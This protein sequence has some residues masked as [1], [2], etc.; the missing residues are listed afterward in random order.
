MDQVDPDVWEDMWFIFPALA[1][2]TRA[3]YETDLSIILGA[4][5]S[6]EHAESFDNPN[7]I[8]NL[9]EIIS[10]NFPDLGT[11]HDDNRITFAHVSFKEYL[12]GKW[13]TSPEALKKVQRIVADAYLKYFQLKDLILMSKYLGRYQWFC[14]G[15]T[16]LTLQQIPANSLF[17]TV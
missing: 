1:V 3:L 12:L 17:V 16:S 8:E 7:A 14:V 15:S 2:A 4:A 11:A 9:S 5:K 10:A 6:R 13:E